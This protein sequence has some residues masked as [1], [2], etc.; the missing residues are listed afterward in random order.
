MS[1]EKIIKIRIDASQAQ[2]ALKTTDKD[3]KDIEKT[4]EKIGTAAQASS[5]GFDIMNVSVKSVVLSLKAMGIGLIVS[6]F[7]ALQSALSKNQKVMDT[8]NIALETISL[9]FQQ[10][11]NT[12]INKGE[13]VVGFFKKIGSAIGKFLKK[14]LDGL[15]SSYEANNEQTESAIQKNKRLAKEIVNLRNEVKLAEAEQRKL[16]LTY[17]R[18][19]ELQRQVRDDVSKTIQERIDAN[20]RLGQILNE[21]FAEEK[22]LAKLKLELAE[23]ELAKNK[24]NVDLKVAVTNAETELID[25]QERITGQRSEQLV[26][27]TTLEDEYKESIKET[28][29]TIVAVTT[30]K[31]G[32]DQ[33]FTKS[34]MAQ[35]DKRLAHQKKTAQKEVEI[36]TLTEES[37]RNIVANSMGQL[38]SLMGEESKA[39]KALA[40]GQALINT[41]SAAAAALSPPPV[42]A[43]PIFG[44]IAAAGAIAAGMANVKKIMSTKL[45]GVTDGGDDG[46][47]PD[48]PSPMGGISGVIP[49]LENITGT[50]TGEPQPVQAFVVETDI[51][52]A[53]ALQEEL[54]IQST[55]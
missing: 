39:G 4:A 20:T 49:N 34:A 43:G 27:Q 44:P 7:V 50:A 22:K 30:A 23:K 38:A 32:A 29:T 28:G 37:K 2:S 36:F 31:M 55:L 8:V 45:P 14:D 21:Q 12:L 6:A 25:L 13:K 40:V 54:D 11:V 51:S 41:Y 9:T 47:P 1:Q 10:I 17:Q 53:Q 52:N 3:A 19:A 15:T 5:K 33:D 48:V 46:P 26:N 18:D 42:G 24:K 16:Q 35:M